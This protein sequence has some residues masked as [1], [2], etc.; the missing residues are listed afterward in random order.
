MGGQQGPG[1][2]PAH[3]RRVWAPVNPALGRK[4]RPVG[5]LGSGGG[6]GGEAPVQFQGRPVSVE[7]VINIKLVAP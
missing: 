1:R 7:Y 4:V 5:P 2:N 6:G 3:G